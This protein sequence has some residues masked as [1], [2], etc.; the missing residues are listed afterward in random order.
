MLDFFHN[1][2]EE[3]ILYFPVCF[4]KIPSLFRKGSTLKEK[5]LHLLQKRP[6]LTSNANILLTELST[7]QRF[8]FSW[9]PSKWGI[10]DL[11]VFICFC[12]NQYFC[13]EWN[14]NKRKMFRKL[15]HLWTL[16]ATFDNFGMDTLEKRQLS[17]KIFLH[18]FSKGLGVLE[19]KHKVPEVFYCVT[20]V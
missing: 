2:T 8:P 3:T 11:F 18:P 1:F 5:I 14:E 13:K 15:C 20:G 10:W 4:P 19:G 6:L 17:E 7:L 12:R 9:R 16:D